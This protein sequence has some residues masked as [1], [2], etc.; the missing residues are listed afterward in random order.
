MALLFLIKNLKKDLAKTYKC[1][2]IMV[3]KGE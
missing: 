2:K 3:R 1:D